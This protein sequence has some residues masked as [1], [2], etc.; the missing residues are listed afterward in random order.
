MEETDENKELRD[1]RRFYRASVKE[2][3]KNDYGIDQKGFL[4]P[5]KTDGNN[6]NSAEKTLRIRVKFIGDGTE[7]ELNLR[8][9]GDSDANAVKRKLIDT[10]P[11][12]FK[13][14]SLSDMFLKK[15]DVIYDDNDPIQI[16]DEIINCLIFNGV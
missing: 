4:S 10:Y 13:G 11:H 14:K 12:I 15:N 3:L 2:K 16:N 5:N 9:S 8:F 6:N 1:S 7:Q